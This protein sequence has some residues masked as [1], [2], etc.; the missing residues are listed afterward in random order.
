MSHSGLRPSGSRILGLLVVTVLIAPQARAELYKCQQPNGRI[1]YQ[2]TACGGHADVEAFA[3]DIRGPD[4]SDGAA[5]GQKY[6]IGSQAAQMRAERER[7][8]GA[9]LK[10]RQASEAAARRAAADSDKEPDRAKCAKHRAEVA[11]WKEKVM[12]GYRTRTQKDYNDSKL[13]YHAALVDRYC[14]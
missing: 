8:N 10:A 7:L 13:A 14:D 2:Q 6:S 4:G 3:V 9:R 12:K 1:I 11:K 5:S